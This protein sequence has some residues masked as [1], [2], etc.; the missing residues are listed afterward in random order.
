MLTDPWFYAAAIPAMIILGIAK[1]GF[2]VIGIVAVPLMA[3]VMSPVQAAGITLPILVLSDIVALASYWGVFDRS[4]V[5]VMLPGGL[6]GIAVG[7]LTATSVSEAEVRLILGIISA[8][9]A[10]DYWFRHRRTTVPAQPNVAKGVF[11]GAIA[12][13]TSFVSHAGGPPFQ[14]YAGPL[15]LEPAIFAGTSVL[16]FA[17]FNAAKVV[18][19]AFLGQFGTENLLASAILLP[20]AIPATMFGVWLV[21]RVDTRVYYDLIYVFIF[22]VGLFL[23]GE[24]SGRPLPALEQP[25]RCNPG[26]VE[27]G[28]NRHQNGVGGDRGEDQSH[29]P[30]DDV[31]P[32]FADHSQ[33][34]TGAQHESQIDAE[35]DEE[36]QKVLSGVDEVEVRRIDEQHRA[37]HRARPGDRRNGE[38]KDGDALGVLEGLGFLLLLFRFRRSEHH[39]ERKEEKDDAAGD[40]EAF[41]RNAERVEKNAPAEHEEDEDQAGDHRRPH[42]DARAHCRRHARGDHQEDGD[43]ADRIDQHPHHDQ[44]IDEVL[45]HGSVATVTW[46]ADPTVRFGSGGAPMMRPP[47]SRNCKG[48]AGF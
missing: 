30:A 43:R 13:F 9:F 4:L 46:L 39:G 29:D 28:R 47:S 10:V 24:S 15:R 26:N 48:L 31:D 14:V 22:L 23:I 37:K 36:D 3:L 5:R 1:G 40:L 7:W 19:Y 20:V 41:E 17:I 45:Q 11:W 8:V 34:R 21:K 27:E 42:G 12:G 18:P 25:A 2:G 38:R 6:L 44:F 32:R 16:L 35:D 33:D